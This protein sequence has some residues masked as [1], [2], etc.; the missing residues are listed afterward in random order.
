MLRGKIVNLN[1]DMKKSAKKRLLKSRYMYIYDHI[2]KENY[3]RRLQKVAFYK[4]ILNFAYKKKSRKILNFLIVRF[5]ICCPIIGIPK[6]SSFLKNYNFHRRQNIDRYE[7]INIEKEL[8]YTDS[9][10]I[11]PLTN[12]LIII[13]LKNTIFC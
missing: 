1:K 8:K 6:L 12:L 3:Q 9:W 13:I 4:M 5:K 7:Q 10:T 2:R 11:S